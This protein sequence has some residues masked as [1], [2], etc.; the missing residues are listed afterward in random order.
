MVEDSGLVWTVT[1]GLTD[2]A[3]KR[4]NVAGTNIY[5]DLD[6]SSSDFIDLDMRRVRECVRPEL[7]GPDLYLRLVNLIFLFGG[8]YY[9]NRRAAPG[10]SG[11]RRGRDGRIYVLDKGR[12]DNGF[13]PTALPAA[14]C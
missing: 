6:F 2:K 3:I 7:D 1:T 5:G 12:N 8:R 10:L 4:F 14:W 13:S 9:E 11:Y